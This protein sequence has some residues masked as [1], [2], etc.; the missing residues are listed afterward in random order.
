[1]GVEI[2][3]KD[4]F[5]LFAAYNQGYIKKGTYVQLCEYS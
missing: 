4:Y 2:K 5:G 1:M 3:I